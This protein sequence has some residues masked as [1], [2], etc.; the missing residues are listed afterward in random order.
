[1][2]EPKYK[3]GQYYLKLTINEHQLTLRQIVTTNLCKLFEENILLHNSCDKY[4]K[5]SSHTLT[6]DQSHS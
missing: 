5:L 6:D 1:M 4:I 3:E 2:S